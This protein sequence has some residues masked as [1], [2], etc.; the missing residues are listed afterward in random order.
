MPKEK[1]NK[2]L[3]QLRTEIEQ[4]ASLPDNDKQRM[5]KLVQDIEQGLNEDKISEEL[6]SKLADTVTEF[7]ATHPRLTAI[8]NDI[9][10]T[11]SN[12]GI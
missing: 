12:M 11:L 7:E 10:V 6:N 2:L 3:H 4:Q 1:A 9:M 5:G 8:I